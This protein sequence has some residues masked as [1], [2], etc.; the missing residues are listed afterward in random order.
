MITGEEF[1]RRIRR[2]SQMRTMILVLRRAATEAWR[3]GRSPYKPQGDIRSDA[4]YWRR[5]I[6]AHP[7]RPQE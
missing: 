3:Q 1:E 2:I 4:D 7:T 5:Q 6:A